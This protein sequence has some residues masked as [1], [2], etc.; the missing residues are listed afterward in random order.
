M[1]YVNRRK[2]SGKSGRKSPV[3][4]RRRVGNSRADFDS[5]AGFVAT[6]ANSIVAVIV[7]VIRSAITVG[8][9]VTA[10]AISARAISFITSWVIARSGALVLKLNDYK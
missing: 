6:V 5:M 4:N 10:T 2:S 9:M 7:S 3:K 8:G 1:R